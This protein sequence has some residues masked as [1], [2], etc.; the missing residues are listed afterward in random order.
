MLCGCA[1]TGGNAAVKS[2]SAHEVAALTLDALAKH[3]TWKEKRTA[4]GID[5]SV[6]PDG[7]VRSIN[8][9]FGIVTRLHAPDRVD[10]TS[11]NMTGPGT[12][13]RQVQVG[14]KTYLQEP[15]GTGNWR[16]L[17]VAP[18][19]FKDASVRVGPILRQVIDWTK[20]V[21]TTDVNCGATQCYRLSVDGVPVGEG[22]LSSKWKIEI[23]IDKT[24][25]LPLRQALTVTYDSDGVGTTDEFEFYDYGQPN[26]IRPP[27]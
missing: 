24:T 16:E 12:S 27:I 10:A 25:M 11:S 5:R 1:A 26:E 2:P 22:V 6:G 9:T 8:H 19:E 4:T 17:T 21:L 14:R 23:V 18:V 20:L 13:S 15:A 7:K 3:T